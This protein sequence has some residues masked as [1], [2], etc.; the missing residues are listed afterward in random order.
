M[1][2]EERRQAF[3]VMHNFLRVSSLEQVD[4]LLQTIVPCVE[5]APTSLSLAALR[6]TTLVRDDL[7]WWVPLLDELHSVAS[8]RG[9]NP[10]ALL[11]GLLA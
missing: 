2:K 6:L 5:A 9:I 4:Q 11:V 10:N 8:A 1:T 7:L 3:F